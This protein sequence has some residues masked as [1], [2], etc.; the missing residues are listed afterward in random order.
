MNSQ[1]EAIGEALDKVRFI[2]ETATSEWSR[3]YW[4]QQEQVLLRQWITATNGATDV[5]ATDSMAV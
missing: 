3:T 4:R 5:Q 1:A 2:L